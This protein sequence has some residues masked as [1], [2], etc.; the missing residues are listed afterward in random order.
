MGW[1]IERISYQ[2]VRMQFTIFPSFL[3]HHVRHRLQF[4]LDFVAVIVV[5]LVAV[6]AVAAAVDGDALAF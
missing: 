4:I 2:F 6:S 1:K 3:C 5:V